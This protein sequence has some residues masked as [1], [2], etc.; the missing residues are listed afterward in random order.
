MLKLYGFSISNY[1]NIVKAAMLEKAL[2]FE[3]VRVYPSADPDYLVRSPMGK[4]P[5]LETEEGVLSETQVMLDFLEEAYPQTPLYPQDAFARAKARELMRVTELY[6]ELPARRLYPEAFFGGS[7]SDQTRREVATD[8]QKGVA[9]LQR[10][11]RF[12]PY[13][14]GSRFGMAD[15]VAAI[16]LPLISDASR[17]VLGEDALAG[18][19]EVKPY[20]TLMRERASMQRVFADYKAG[21]EDFKAQK[22]T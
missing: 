9:A 19:A 11:A 20:L 17:R 14:A 2:E 22:R 5:S 4:V 7:V 18:V 16:H 3:E 21:L 6:L 1:Y 10:L 8:L 12:E 15:L 13:I